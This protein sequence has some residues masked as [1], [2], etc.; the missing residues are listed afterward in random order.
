M[1]LNIQIFKILI[2][3]L[4]LFETCSNCVHFH[5]WRKGSATNNRGIQNHFLSCMSMM[6]ESHPTAGDAAR[7]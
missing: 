5:T 3:L 4:T 1:D 6:H 2:Q 7:W